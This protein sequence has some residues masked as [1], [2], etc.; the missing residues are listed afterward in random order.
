M[1]LYTIACSSDGTVR[2]NLT[3]DL[4]QMVDGALRVHVVTLLLE[5]YKQDA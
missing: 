1:V 5:E 4:Y 3:T 2:V